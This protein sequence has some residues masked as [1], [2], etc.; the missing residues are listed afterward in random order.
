M[1]KIGITGGIGS[2]K[3]TAANYLKKKFNAYIFNADIESK[4]LLTNSNII[5]KKLINTFGNKITKDRKLNIPL[6]ADE[7]FKSKLNQELI[8][9]TYILKE[10]K[11]AL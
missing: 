3:T 8:T 6:L 2:G 7:V 4:N 9:Y 10:K 11:N 5:Q 1:Y